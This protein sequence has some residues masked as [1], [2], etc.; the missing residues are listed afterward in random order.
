MELRKSWLLCLVA[1][2]AVV[3]PMQKVFTLCLARGPWRRRPRLSKLEN[4][5]LEDGREAEEAHENYTRFCTRGKRD[6]WFS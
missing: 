3:S 4:K 1:A 6:S 5:V 2:E